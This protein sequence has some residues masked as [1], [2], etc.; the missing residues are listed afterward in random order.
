MYTPTCGDG[1]Q[2]WYGPGET[3]A[4]GQV[5]NR[6]L[7]TPL[8]DGG[9]CRLEPPEHEPDCRAV[10]LRNEEN[11]LGD[12]VVVFAQ[13]LPSFTSGGRRPGV[14]NRVNV[15]MTPTHAETGYEF[16]SDP[17]IYKKWRETPGEPVQITI[18]NIVTEELA[19]IG[20]QSLRFRAMLSVRQGYEGP[21]FDEIED[22]IVIRE[23]DV[24]ALITVRYPAFVEAP[25]DIERLAQIQLQRIRGTVEAQ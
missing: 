17:D 24:V 15:Y 20:D 11:L 14:V 25:V 10:N 23:R 4:C 7:T 3:C 6:L 2:H 22:V 19:R 12:I 9:G 16:Q 13:H 5:P 18:E 8:C 1:N 21:T